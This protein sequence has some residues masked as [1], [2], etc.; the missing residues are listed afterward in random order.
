[1]QHS[2]LC[3]Q[4][5]EN[6][7]L[8]LNQGISYRAIGRE[9]G[10]HHSTI[11]RELIRSQCRR[12]DYRAMA[13]QEMADNRNLRS[14]RKS[15]IDTKPELFKEVFD[16]LFKYWSPKQI[17]MAL[18]KEHP[19]EPWY[20]ISHETIYQHI[21]AFPR[22][23]LKR[24]MVSFLRQKKRLRGGRGKV[25]LKKQVIKDFVPI[26]ERP[27]EVEGRQVPGHWEGDLII[28]KGNKSAMGTLV[29]R[30][31]RMV[32]LVPLKARKAKTVAESFSEIFEELSPE[33]T[34]SLTYDRG[35][36]M[37]GH[38]YFTKRTGMPVYFADP[39]SPWQRGSCENTNMLLRDF[40]PK[41]TDLSEVSVERI[42]YVQNC[43]NERPRETLGWKT[44]K[45]VFYESIS[46]AT[47]T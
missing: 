40:F 13:A 35:T 23:E 29:E 5:R 17:S 24:A 38:K 34:K 22:G 4:E 7:A 14:G 25:K 31:S 27:E 15:F 36:E 43:L 46:G 45:E 11:L 42:K 37:A 30:K 19:D 21:Y 28:G 16:R 8:L 20:W 12:K 26:A 2:R 10:R 47:V 18:K 32:F 3:V 33:L 44:P 41:G 1:M 39:H 9:I 6:I